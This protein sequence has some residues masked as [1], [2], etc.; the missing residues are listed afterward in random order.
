M[1]VVKVVPSLDTQAYIYTNPR[2]KS[3]IIDTKFKI[4]GH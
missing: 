4:N 1:I 2:H 3:L